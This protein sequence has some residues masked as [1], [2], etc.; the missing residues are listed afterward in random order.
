MNV[1]S[2]GHRIQYK[3]RF[4]FFIVSLKVAVKKIGEAHSNSREVLGG[5]VL[6]SRGRCTKNIAGQVLLQWEDLGSIRVEHI[7]RW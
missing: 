6:G 4:A 3:W 7:G 5:E 2:C 1:L